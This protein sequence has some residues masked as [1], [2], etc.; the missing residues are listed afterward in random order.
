MVLAPGGGL[1][2][3]DLESLNA[4]QLAG[5]GGSYSHNK[6]L[7]QAKKEDGRSEKEDLRS[8]KSE[9]DYG[10]KKKF[11]D[12]IGNIKKRPTLDGLAD[13]PGAKNLD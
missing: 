3:G 8:I 4:S 1:R 11:V 13:H 9:Y 10:A 7:L 6:T 2:A 12:V 5:H